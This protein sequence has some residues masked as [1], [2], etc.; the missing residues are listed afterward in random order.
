MDGRLWSW[1]HAHEQHPELMGPFIP[2]AVFTLED[3]DRQI[4]GP[5]ARSMAA[6]GAPELADHELANNRLAIIRSEQGV[7]AMRAVDMQECPSADL[8]IAE[9]IIAVLKAM[10]NGRWV[11]NYLQRAWSEGDLVAIQLQVIKDAG[12]ALIS[13]RDLLFMFGLLKQD[14]MTASK[15]WQHLFVEL[16]GDLSEHTRRHIGL[17]LEHGC[18]SSRILKHTGKRPS[19]DRLTATYQEIARCL[20]EDRPFL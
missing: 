20:Q 19:T 5:L 4:T 18:L 11:S 6:L 3:L 10:A 9:F 16:Y 13:N 7:V 12:N 8:A 1:L 17:V 14:Q 2:E 15:L